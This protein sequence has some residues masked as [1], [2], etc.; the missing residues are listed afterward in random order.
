L[1]GGGNVAAQQ[2]PES[3]ASHY[4]TVAVAAEMVPAGALALVLIEKRAK[5]IDFG[6]R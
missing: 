4:K 2:D 5:P 3:R 1:R 6:R